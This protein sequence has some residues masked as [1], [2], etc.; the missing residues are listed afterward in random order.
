MTITRIPRWLI[1]VA[2]LALAVAGVFAWRATQGRAVEVVSPSPTRLTQTVVVSG[3]VLAP[4]K[5][6][7]GATITGR[8]VSVAVDDGD[9]VAAGQTLVRLETAELSA[10]LAQAVA[11]ERTAETRIR[12]WSSVGAPNAREQLAQ[13]EANERLAQ[14]E[15]DRQ[16][17]LFRQGFIG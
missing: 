12:Q 15:L 11:S 5:V 9:R 14:A 7:I 8:V 2:A 6:E 17:A 1:G 13:A 3:R 16:D 4:A 10:A